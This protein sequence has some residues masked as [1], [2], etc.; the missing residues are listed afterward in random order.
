MKLI[1]AIDVEIKKCITIKQE[2]I[3]MLRDQ[4]G[5]LLQTLGDCAILAGFDKRQFTIIFLKLLRNKFLDHVPFISQG[6]DK[7]SKAVF[8]QL[9]KDK[10]QNGLIMDFD[11]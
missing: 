9:K 8:V 10:P 2:E 1:H 7:M 6:K 11:E 4:V 5:H 3:I